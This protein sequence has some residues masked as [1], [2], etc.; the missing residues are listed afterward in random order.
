LAFGILSERLTVEVGLA[1]A[2]RRYAE[3]GLGKILK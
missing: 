2:E 3:R 1:H